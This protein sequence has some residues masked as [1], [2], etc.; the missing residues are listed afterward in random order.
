MTYNAWGQKITGWSAINIY[1]WT[2]DEKTK[3]TL[4]DLRKEKLQ[5]IEQAASEG[6]HDV[7]AS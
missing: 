4:D 5:Q 1:E 7:D 3:E 2:V 6:N